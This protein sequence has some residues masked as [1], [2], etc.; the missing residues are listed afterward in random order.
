[1][2]LAEYAKAHEKPPCVICS[3]PQREEIDEGWQNG[4]KPATI[5]SYLRSL[6]HEISQAA[7]ESHR[8]NHVRK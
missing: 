7:W 5:L 2:N 1:M 4:I 3:L 8:K 6:G